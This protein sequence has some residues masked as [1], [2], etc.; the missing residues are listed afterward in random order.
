MDIVN[1][2]L[3]DDPQLSDVIPIDPASQDI[4]DSVN[5]CSEKERRKEGKSKDRNISI[6]DILG[7]SSVVQ[8]GEHYSATYHRL[9]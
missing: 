4:F 2:L 9:Q 5:V 8:T 1:D 6:N 7:W 3:K